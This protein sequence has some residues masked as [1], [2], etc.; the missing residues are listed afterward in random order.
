M[1]ERSGA[2]PVEEEVFGKELKLRRLTRGLTMVELAKLS[3]VSPSHIGR[4]ERGER[5]PSYDIA[6]KLKKALGAEGG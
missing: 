3:G 2:S 4:I 6:I 1:F 5:S